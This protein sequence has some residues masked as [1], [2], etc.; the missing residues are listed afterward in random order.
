MVP[1]LAKCVFVAPDVRAHAV[2]EM[3]V[4]KIHRG[5]PNPLM[6]QCSTSLSSLPLPQASIATG[7]SQT[8]FMSA[9]PSPMPSPL[10]LTAP[11]ARRVYSKY[12]T[13]PETL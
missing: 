7:S 1:H 13:T 10:L 12:R 2:Q 4:K 9:T 8:G 6:L 3:D 5:L 11:G